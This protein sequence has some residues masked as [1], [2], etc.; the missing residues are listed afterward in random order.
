MIQGLGSEVALLLIRIPETFFVFFE[1]RRIVG[2]GEHFLQKPGNDSWKTFHLRD[3]DR[4]QVLHRP[5]HFTSAKRLIPKDGDVA[6]L[7]LGT[8]LDLENNFKRGG[9]NPAKFRVHDGEFVAAFREKLLQ[10]NGCMVDH[11]RIV[12]RL[13]NQ[14]DL[15]LLEPIQNV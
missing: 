10:D 7:N 1:L 13:H 3:P 11:V 8:F 14:P 9:R 15:L 6:D 2:F 12:L 5:N 4:L